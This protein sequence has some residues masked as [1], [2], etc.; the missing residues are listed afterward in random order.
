MCLFNEKAPEFGIYVCDR[1]IDYYE[2][3]YYSILS[4]IILKVLDAHIFI[5]VSRNF[6]H[7]VDILGPIVCSCWINS[8]NFHIF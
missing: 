3:R 8:I 5:I 2:I 4:Y 6:Y 1:M 7:S